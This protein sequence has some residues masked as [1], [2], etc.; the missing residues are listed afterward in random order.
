MF[1]IT[2]LIVID[3]VEFLLKENDKL[4][5][6]NAKLSATLIHV[7]KQVEDLQKEN[8]S[9]RGQTTSGATTTPSLDEIDLNVEP[10]GSIWKDSTIDVCVLYGEDTGKYEIIRKADVIFHI[11]KTPFL[12]PDHAQ[13]SKKICFHIMKNKKL[14]SYDS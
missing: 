2:Q 8:S 3:D 12:G 14:V 6:D 10:V 4:R 11:M 1:F 7:Q 5:L 13:S 9:L